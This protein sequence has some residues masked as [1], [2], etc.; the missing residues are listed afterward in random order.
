MLKLANGLI[1]NPFFAN[2][3]CIRGG[4]KSKMIMFLIKRFNL[5][6]KFQKKLLTEF[7]S[8]LK[9]I[10]R[11][12]CNDLNFQDTI[13]PGYIDVQAL[14]YESKCITGSQTTK[15]DLGRINLLVNY[16]W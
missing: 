11:N 8:D 12:M 1:K 10:N 3:C 9:L 14:Y 16:S 5:P 4:S 13:Q 15:Y 2:E 6:K 7:D